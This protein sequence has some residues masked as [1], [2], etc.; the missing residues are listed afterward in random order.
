M[1]QI[2]A[3]MKSMGQF[4]GVPSGNN[5]RDIMR[6]CCLCLVIHSLAVM[7]VLINPD[8]IIDISLL[9]S[10]ICF[11]NREI[12]FVNV[13]GWLE[14]MTEITVVLLSA[15]MLTSFVHYMFPTERVVVLLSLGSM[16]LT[17]LASAVSSSIGRLLLFMKRNE[18][19]NISYLVSLLV[20]SQIVYCI[21]I[22][23]ILWVLKISR[24]D[25]FLLSNL[26]IIIVLLIDASKEN[27][28][29]GGGS[30]ELSKPS[31][32]KGGKQPDI[33]TAEGGTVK[34]RIMGSL[35]SCFWDIVVQFQ[36]RR[37]NVIKPKRKVDFQKVIMP[38]PSPSSSFA[39][40]ATSEEISLAEELGTDL[41][42]PMDIILE[43]EGYVRECILY[44]S[45]FPA[46]YDFTRDTLIWSWLAA[47][48]INSEQNG[49]REAMA[50]RCFDKLIRSEYILHSGYDYVANQMMYRLGNERESL[51]LRYGKS[52]DIDTNVAELEHLSLIFE[53]IDQIPFDILGE[54][55]R[56]KTLLLHQCYGSKLENLLNDLFLKL[57][58]LT[59][60]DLS[61]TNIVE[62]PSSVENLK[63]LQYLDM[64]K[65][66]IRRLPESID[67][68]GSLET[69]T[70]VG[71]LNLYG[72][73]KCT[74]KLINL[75]HLVL[76]ISSMPI[77]IGKLTNLQ[78]L[79][80]FLVGTKEGTHVE[81]LRNMNKLK[82]SLCIMKLE[83][84]TNGEEA[85]KALLCDK[86]YITKLELIWSDIQDTK[87]TLEEEILKSIQ[88][89]FGL[90]ELKIFFYSGGLLPS[91]ISDPSFTQI[92]SITLHGC[93]YCEKLPSLGD[94]PSLKFLNVVEMDGLVDIDELFCRKGDNR[95]KHAFP[96]LEKLSF[97]GMS[98]LK[99]WTGVE[100][101]DFPC[102]KELMIKY[103]PKLVDVPSL[104]YLISLQHLE[105][106][107][108][109]ELPCLPEDG[110]PTSLKCLMVNDC[111][112][113]KERL[114]EEQG[115]N[116]IKVVFEVFAIGR[117][118][119]LARE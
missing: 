52:L 51:N 45:I 71:C 98:N 37:P 34:E 1:A 61:C 19:S 7:L 21:V 64:S 26:V 65:T 12:I 115:E 60:L 84:V 68:L 69:L 54:D 108:C 100:D 24:F 81:E 20:M 29:S 101:G 106:I 18:E 35:R 6:F 50:V 113:F 28:T 38:P 96:Q 13:G 109:P 3:W 105:I 10:I 8:F 118:V 31:G 25:V 99:K 16:I 72:L 44:C 47:G 43:K 102:L 27:R 85:G 95:E 62:L 48:L 91:W 103:C 39:P 30:S 14:L 59:T 104:S 9:N 83:N 70:L 66:P 11:L 75:Q 114:C 58:F 41:E 110:L 53:G 42:V 74:N 2:K 79:R 77:G 5:R 80:T 46:D 82:G 93:R 22:F 90:E 76:D 92:S 73:P 4:L 94:L 40:I 67:S 86:K 111:P 89:H 112:K 32:R 55:S 23:P 107:D 87:L 63:A 49:K 78:T 97:N 117:E 17:V 116:C 57:K 33:P 88:P 56:L 36:S 15:V 119:V